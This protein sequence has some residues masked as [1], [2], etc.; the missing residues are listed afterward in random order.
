MNKLYITANKVSQRWVYIFGG[1]IPCFIQNGDTTTRS[2][3]F[4]NRMNKLYI[5]ANK[6]SQR[7]VYIF[8]GFIPCFIQNWLVDGSRTINY[9]H[10][11]SIP[12]K[13]GNPSTRLHKTET[14]FKKF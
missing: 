14:K 11:Y 1:F 9:L 7:L 5:T 8:G 3:I 13:L 12:P 6:V 10:D 2:Q 4:R